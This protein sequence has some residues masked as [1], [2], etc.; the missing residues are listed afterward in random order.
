M[1]RTG[2]TVNPAEV[3][4]D[5]KADKYRFWKQQYMS[6][7]SQC[8]A[9]AL[10]VWEASYK[11]CENG[12]PDLVSGHLAEKIR[13]ENKNCTDILSEVD[14]FEKRLEKFVIKYDSFPFMP[15][16]TPYSSCDSMLMSLQESGKYYWEFANT[17]CS[18]S[19][20]VK[21]RLK[22]NKLHI[23]VDLSKP[24]S[25][26]LVDFKIVITQPHGDQLNED[27]F[28]SLHRE[29]YSDKLRGDISPIPRAIGV[30]IWD[31]LVKKHNHLSLPHGA[32]TEAIDEL[33]KRFDLNKLGYGKSQQKVLEDKYRGTCRCIE[34]CEV[35]P[36]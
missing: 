30:W 33:K 28:L 22:N 5:D 21:K 24:V 12:L 4:Q 13:S 14:D 19:V 34:F 31:Y 9:L 1:E 11:L 27:D 23:V 8:V 20:F 25:E 15:L 35:L 16:A 29:K 36:F 18:R 6:R 7:N 32:L 2:N 17:L 3:C 26:I 10:E